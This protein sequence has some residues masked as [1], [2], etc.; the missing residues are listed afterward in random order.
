MDITTILT[1]AFCISIVMFLAAIGISFAFTAWQDDGPARS[2][3]TIMISTLL[4]TLSVVGTANFIVM[5]EQ[6]SLVDV[7][8]MIGVVVTVVINWWVVRNIEPNTGRR[9]AFKGV[10]R[11]PY[12]EVE[13]IEPEYI[14]PTKPIR[15]SPIEFGVS[16]ASYF[17]AG[18]KS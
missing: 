7:A 9:S 14:N 11:A 16:D 12:A 2:E 1:W 15:R 3:I 6:K 5:F 13:F 4:A 17:K 10:Y 18:K 8:L